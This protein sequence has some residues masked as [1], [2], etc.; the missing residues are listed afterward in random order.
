MRVVM[1]FALEVDA[2]EITTELKAA[3]EELAEVM[4]VQT[5]DGLIAP[6]PEGVYGDG[7][8]V[9]DISKAELERWTYQ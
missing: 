8:H 9:A 3:I 7:T 2:E 4:L 1:T 5:E 6:S